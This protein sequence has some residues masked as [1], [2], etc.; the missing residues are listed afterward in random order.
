MDEQLEL[1]EKSPFAIRLKMPEAFDIDWELY[2]K[3]TRGARASYY[4]YRM[5]KEYFRNKYLDE[6]NEEDVL[7]FRRERESAGVS[8]ATINRDQAIIS[9]TFN[10][11]RKWKKLRKVNGIVTEHWD[12]PAENP[13]KEVKKTDETMRVRKR[14]LTRKEFLTFISFCSD[15]L[16][17]VCLMAIITRL[18]QSDLRKLRKSVHLNNVRQSL[19]GIQSKTICNR[20]PSGVPFNVPI[21]STIKK[22]IH[23]AKADYILDFS[24]FRHEFVRARSRW[25]EKHRYEKFILSDLRRSGG[26]YLEDNG[27]PLSTVSAGYGHKHL[28]TTQLYNQSTDKKLVNAMM[29]LDIAFGIGKTSYLTKGKGRRDAVAAFP[30][31]VG[32]WR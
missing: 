18:R 4:R 14:I 7:R 16:K 5:L 29:V 26:V 1:F 6:L 19:S 12:L 2:G 24:N 3:F 23:E 11:L 30:R 25:M 15:R 10:R 13:C 9:S 32:K 27:I 21:T 28:R 8:G 17:K 20:N 31:G 22:I